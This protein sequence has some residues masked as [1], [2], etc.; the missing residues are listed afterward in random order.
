MQ[1]T[2]QA[3]KGMVVYRPGTHSRADLKHA[4]TALLGQGATRYHV[5]VCALIQELKPKKR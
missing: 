3:E 1:F 4:L 2:I 5:L